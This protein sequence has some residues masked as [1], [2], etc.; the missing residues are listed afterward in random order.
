MYVMIEFCAFFDS[1]LSSSKNHKGKCMRYIIDDVIDGRTHKALE[2]MRIAVKQGGA[3]TVLWGSMPCTGGCTWNYING[4]TPEGR[5]RIEEHI[6][7]MTQ[8]LKNF[9]IA[10]KL[11]VENGGIVCFEWPKRCTYWKRSDIQNMINDLGL[12]PAHFDGCSFGL[13]STN[14]GKEHMFLKKP[15]TIYSNC[16]ILNTM[17]TKRVCPGVNKYHVHDQC[18]GKNA[19]GSERYT[20]EFARSVH[21]ALRNSFN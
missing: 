5:A 16:P 21:C 19:K 20:D 3:Y 7:L 9:I 8:L 11:V 12:E 1:L 10:A 17:L 13:K 18:R 2:L 14:K 6:V 15:W 4:K